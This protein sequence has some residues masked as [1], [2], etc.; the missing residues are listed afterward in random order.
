[1]QKIIIVCASF[2]LTVGML[3]GCSN[4]NDKAAENTVNRSSDYVK[5][6]IEKNARKTKND[7]EESIDHMMKYLKDE[8]VVYENMQ[9]IDQI[10]FAAHEGRSFEINGN[11]VYLYRVKSEDENMK[12]LL[13]QAEETGRVKV[14]IDNKE[15][16]YMA[17]VNGTYL[18][19]Y[20]QNVKADDLQRVFPNYS[21]GNLQETNPYQDQSM[22][23][24]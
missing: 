14:R 4:K 11:K 17:Q 12:K 8:G 2:A 6:D 13:R 1:M 7:V 19:L 21:Q 24:E 9:N 20:D 16:E 5:K 22:K 23:D 15:K 3:G 10:D 18:M